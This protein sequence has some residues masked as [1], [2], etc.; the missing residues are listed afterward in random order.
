MTPHEAAKLC[1]IK[2]CFKCKREKPHS[3]FYK[4][5]TR[6]DGLTD[7]CKECNRA[8]SRKWKANNPDKIRAYESLP[9]TIERKKRYQDENRERIRIVQKEW[10]HTNKSKVDRY[11]KD[12][13]D[14]H[15]DRKKESSEKWRK[16]NMDKVNASKRRRRKADPEK[17]RLKARELYHRDP[18][19]HR[20]I[21]RRSNRRN[22]GKVRERASYS[23]HRR[24][25]ATP[26]W[27]GSDQRSEIR[28]FYEC[29]VMM[30]EAGYEK[31]HVDH[32]VPIAGANVCG[33][34]VPWNLQILPASINMS[35]G[36]R[37][38]PY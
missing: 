14:R 15:P 23:A 7:E 34:H 21:Q 13:R 9:S 17:Y 26:S 33:L 25:V 37:N 10:R 38:E 5:R 3:E 32:I 35:K 29:A 36:N 16:A 19:R 8:Y 1:E 6:E 2:L 22:A 20:M 24:G 31:R 18:E 12:Y 27:L 11:H 28:S 30:E 4:N